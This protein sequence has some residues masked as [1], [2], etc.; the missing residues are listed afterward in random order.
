MS[1]FKVVDREIK[2]FVKT[3]LAWV[4]SFIFPLTMSIIICLIFGKGTINNL[5]IAVWNADNSQLSRML[6]RNLNF[7]PACH[8]KYNINS[9]E[10][11]KNL[12][13]EG[14]V[15]GIVVIP[16][17]FQRDLYRMSQPK[18]VFYYNN[19]RILIG[20]IISR[21]VNMMVQSMLVALDA[22]MK[23]KKGLPFEEAVKQS[24]L[25]NVVDH[26]RSN[27]YFNY[28]YLLAVAAL[29]HII[30]ISIAMTSVWTI[31]SEFKFGKTKE[32][33]E[34]A[35]GSIVVAFLGKMTPYLIIFL[36]LLT[37]VYQLYFGI[38]MAPYTGN[39]IVGILATIVFVITCLSMGVIFMSVNGN[40]RFGLS[41]CAFY[42]AIGFALAG[43]TFP[44]MAMPP[45]IKVYTSMMPLNYWVQIML[46]QSIRQIPYIYDLKFFLPSL[47]IT[48][49]GLLALYRLKKLALD[50][51]R[52]FQS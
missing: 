24:N 28:L 20:G 39:I 40:F 17:D 49:V 10:E 25:I 30:Q 15:Y 12:L 41:F 18:L 43:V 31:G 45:V 29:G 1:Y 21:D 26:I 48:F 33:I 42:V 52:W 2:R 34:T 50:E 6:V 5:P 3:P 51:N 37:L 9:I 27:P 4:I 35:N 47:C 11:G 32:W 7:L 19:Q 16:K 44:V 23:S 38:Y 14:K 8:V 22:K 36:A 13:I 46:D